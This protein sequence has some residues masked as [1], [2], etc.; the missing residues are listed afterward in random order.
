VTQMIMTSMEGKQSGD[1]KTP[2]ISK[3]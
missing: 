1:G 3:R 2:K